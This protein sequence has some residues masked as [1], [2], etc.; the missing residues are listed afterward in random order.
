MEI[1]S[2]DMF[3]VTRDADFTVSDEADDLLRAVE[4]ELRRRRFGEVVRLEV[5]AGMDERLR[6]RLIDWL[7]VEQRQVYDVSGMLDLSDLIELYEV[8][9]HKDLREAPW[10]PVTQE[11]FHAEEGEQA[12]IFRAMRKRDLLV[13][14]PY[15]SFT[16]SVERLVQQ[17]VND[18]DVLAIKLT[19]Y[20]TSDDSTIIPSLIEAGGGGKQTGGMGELE[21]GLGGGRKIGWGGPPG[22]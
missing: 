4:Y 11:A 8:E 2:H 1:V 14:Q 22:R 7:A 17:A 6:S 20:R 19:V 9:G 12:D 16:T 18:P 21:G 3:R 10:S 13:H 5:G 15:D